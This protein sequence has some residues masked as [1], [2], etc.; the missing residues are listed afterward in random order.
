MM[1]ALARQTSAF[2]AALLVF[3]IGLVL[4]AIAAAVSLWL[5]ARSSA[6]TGQDPAR[7]I[8]RNSAGPLLI[9]LAVRAIDLSFVVFLYRLVSKSDIGDYNLAGLLVTLIL[10]TIGD[11]GLTVWFT[12]EVARDP[13]ALRRLF[14]TTLLLRWGL[15]LLM[16]PLA[17]LVIGAYALL[18][19]VA[20]I[21]HA[22]PAQTVILI[23]ILLPSLLP[24]GFAGAVSAVYLAHE[25]PTTPALVN[26]LN[27]CL[28]TLL[29]LALIL[30]GFRIVGVAWAALI[31]T[32]INAS[33]FAWLLLRRWGWPGWSWDSTTARSMLHAAFPL[34]LNGLLVAV[35]FR[36]DTFIIQGTARDGERAVA[37]YNTAYKFASLALVLP[38]IVI[39]A[40]FPMFARQALNDRAALLRGYRLT[41]RLLLLLAIPLA[42]GLSFWAPQAIR[43]LSGAEYVAAGGPALRLLIWFAPLSYVNGVAQYVLIALDRQSTITWAFL[44]TAIFNL[45]VNLLTVPIWGIN[46][47]AV[48]TVLSELVLYLPFHLV[49]KRELRAAPFLAVAWR[50]LLAALGGSAA[51]LLLRA[52]PG[53]AIATGVV[54]YASSLWLLATF[55]AEDRR[56]LARLRGKTVLETVTPKTG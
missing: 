1:A 13:A 55:D 5:N 46:A 15:A 38:P 36:F 30:L 48:V 44:V 10:A 7:R 8:F 2:R 56:L 32:I 17:A 12:R 45:A 31:A 39:N 42:A 21:P 6:T 22:L 4:L 28:S 51:M 29:Q 52:W 41:V 20:L 25:Q 49:L 27:N 19:S 16:I 43:L 14:G 11:W 18:H 23:A 47:A 3:I 26:L 40:L 33:V 34:M 35:F 54:V 50:P 24:S 53:V 9:Q 37:D